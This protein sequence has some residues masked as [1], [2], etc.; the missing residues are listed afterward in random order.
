MSQYKGQE[1][2][3]HPFLR[4]T[5]DKAREPERE[6]LKQLARGSKQEQLGGLNFAFERGY[7]KF[8]PAAERIAPAVLSVPELLR[9]P[10]GILEI[11][12][13]TANI[14][15]IARIETI[16]E[17]VRRS[18]AQLIDEILAM[19]DY[20]KI[21]IAKKTIAELIDALTAKGLHLGMDVDAILGTK[22]GVLLDGPGEQAA[23]PSS[24]IRKIGE[25]FNGLGP[26]TMGIL[27]HIEEGWA[28]KDIAELLGGNLTNVYNAVSNA[29]KRVLEQLPSCEPVSKQEFESHRNF[30]ERIGLG[31]VRKVHKLQE[32]AVEQETLPA[33]SNTVEAII[34][35]MRDKTRSVL[36]KHE[37]DSPKGVAQSL[38][39]KEQDV[40]ITLDKAA[41]RIKS[42]LRSCEK[43][44]PQAF[45]KYP[46]LFALMGFSNLESVH[47][48][49]NGKHVVSSKKRPFREA[50][51][52]EH[53]RVKKVINLTEMGYKDGEIATAAGVLLMHVAR[54]RNAA[55]RR[56]EL[57]L[58][59]CEEIDPAT[60]S[61]H[62]KLFSLMG[63][64]GIE[65]VHAR[66][67]SI[68][69][70]A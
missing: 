67:K 31:S 61:E 53:A 22:Q 44:S 63:L 27:G 69:P 15:R 24:R 58:P 11:S 30:F 65:E 62:K 57:S 39:M 3:V 2:R 18:E 66:Q 60:Y 45:K 1:R 4:S 43:V 56:L 6:L 47:H 64:D 9:K 12:V 54:I 36:E 13:R 33:K 40:N 59:S 38:R 16:S 35:R 68:S 19:R 20:G 34:G 48:V 42:L 8:E 50:F 28:D 46:K 10:V 49:Q 70:I 52:E 17:L 37:V 21:R 32:V 5:I 14:L 26:K 29:K 51:S 41:T 25:I 23:A 55:L 7:V